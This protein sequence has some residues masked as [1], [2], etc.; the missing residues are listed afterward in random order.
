MLVSNW[1]ES[2][3]PGWL[4]QQNGNL[5][6]CIDHT[7]HTSRGEGEIVEKALPFG[8]VL[9]TVERLSLEDQETL[10][11]IIRRRII[12]RRRAELARDMHEAQ[13]E[14]RT[15]GARPATP[16]ELVKEILS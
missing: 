11:D 12:E 14:F 1:A 15:G 8:E 13:E 3:R 5:Q 10:V 4:I 9:E 6:V 16:D 2:P 7:R